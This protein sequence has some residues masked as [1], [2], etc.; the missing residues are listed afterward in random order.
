MAKAKIGGTSG[1]KSGYI[2]DTLY[3]VTRNDKGELIQLS[4]ARE[5]A[6]EYSNTDQQALNRMLMGT[7]EMAMATCR[8]YVKDT[9]QDAKTLKIAYQMFSAYNYALIKAD[10]EAHW[11]NGYLFDYPDK[12]QKERR[13]GAFLISDGSLKF[14][15]AGFF[16][17]GTWY[18]QRI[19]FMAAGW[20]TA[21]TMAKFK[22]RNHFG[23]GDTIKFFAFCPDYDTYKG[24][25]H[26]CYL[27]VSSSVSDDTILTAENCSEIFSV[28]GNVLASVHFDDSP[29]VNALMIDIANPAVL[30]Y[31]YADGFAAV[32]MRY[33]RGRRLV[34]SNRLLSKN[35]RLEEWG[36]WQSPY[37]A[38]NYS[39]NF[40][41]L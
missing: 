8:G 34:S 13:G 24:T 9:F 3:Q 20:P 37:Q 12:S 33:D 17:G 16:D 6:R 32:L 41:N 29:N 35:K 25:M 1:K 19:R 36:S 40:E 38:Y 27:T 28:Y 2:G 31:H 18:S 7:I 10:A 26:T 5:T 15:W 14:D 22:E 4:R 30:S 11:R 21:M 39:W 23:Q